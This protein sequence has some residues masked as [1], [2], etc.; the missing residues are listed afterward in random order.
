MLNEV[1]IIGH[2]GNIESKT[3]PSGSAM[4]KLSIAVKD[5]WKDK[6]GEWQEKTTWF[7]VQT[8]QKLAEIIVKKASVG[9]LV[10]VKG[11]MQPNK[12]TDKNGVEHNI[13]N[14]IVNEFKN[15]T[16]KSQREASQPN[17][18]RGNVKEPEIVSFDDDIPW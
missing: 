5:G 11:K 15:L 12:Y 2:V 9:N 7:G 13:T 4:T 1:T 3:L 16:P 10:Y 8:Y 14:I 17:E 18:N 6:Q